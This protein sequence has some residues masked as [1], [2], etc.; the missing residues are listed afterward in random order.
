MQ[1][2]AVYT[3]NIQNVA[4]LQGLRVSLLGS[5]IILYVA[6][7]KNFVHMFAKSNYKHHVL[8]D[9]GVGVAYNTT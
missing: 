4:R 5:L 1:E 6:S 3:P 8:L 9:Q 2:H 7:N